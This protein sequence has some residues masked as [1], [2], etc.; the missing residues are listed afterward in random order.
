MPLLGGIGQD[1]V[2]Q[3]ADSIQGDI[4]QLAN[5]AG[6][7][8]KIAANDMLQIV[9]KALSGIQQIEAPVIEQIAGLRATLDKAVALLERIDG[10]KVTATIQLGGASGGA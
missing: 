6:G 10:A 9:T 3:L 5:A 7:V 4:V 1:T 8:E 2:K